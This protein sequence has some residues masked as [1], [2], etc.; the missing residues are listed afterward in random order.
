MEGERKGGEERMRGRGGQEWMR[1]Q[2]EESGR[3]GKAKR[4]RR[5]E[6]EWRRVKEEG[7][8]KGEEDEGRS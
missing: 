7:R 4:R 2:R 6:V 3:K 8:R 1:T 5:G